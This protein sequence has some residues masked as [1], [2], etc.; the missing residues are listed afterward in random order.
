MC[1]AH[2]REDLAMTSPTRAGR[3]VLLV[4]QTLVFAT[5]ALLVAVDLATDVRAGATG[6]HVLLEAA[7]IGI[8]SVA[9][10]VTALRVRTLAQEAR[11]L[12][13]QASELAAH[14]AAS[15]QE[16][17]RWRAEA[18]D[19]IAGLSSAID[20]Q[21]TRWD[22][23]PAEREVALLLLKGLSHKEVAE[24]RDVNETTVRQQARAIYRKA[25]LTGRN[26]LAAFFLEDLLGPRAPL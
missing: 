21:F 13:G 4:I 5:M 8:G 22:L 14:L 26:D 9:A 12:R 18:A 17:D 7:V 1:N 19:L 16:A 10:V 2:D 15:R 20:Q 23:T 6:L 11:E 24:V 25:G 3:P